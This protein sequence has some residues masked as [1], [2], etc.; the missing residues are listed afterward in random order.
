MNNHKFILVLFLSFFLSM[1]A[2]AD[3]KL[4]SILNDNMVLQ[5]NSRVKLWGWADKGEKITIKLSWTKEII[6]TIANNEGKWIVAFRTIAAGGPYRIEIEG[7]NKIILNNILLGE[8][9]ICSG[10]SNMEFTI[11]MLGGW[12]YYKKEFEDLMQYDYSNVRLCQIEKDASPQLKDDCKSHWMKADSS[13][14]GNFSATAWFF[15]RELSKRLKVPI[16]LV[17]SNWGGTQA[18]A[19]TETSFLAKDKDLSY[20]LTKAKANEAYPAIQSSLYNAMINPLINYVIKGAIWYQGESNIDEAELYNKLFPA[21]IKSWRQAWN[22]GDFPFYYVQIA[23]YNYSGGINSSA[24]LREAQMKALNVVNTG[25]VVTLDIGDVNNI[26]PKDKSAVGKRLSLWALN[27]TYLQKDIKVFSGPVYKKMK[28]ERT[29]IRLYFDHANSGLMSK[30]NNISGF[31]IAGED[32]KFITAD[33]VIDGSTLLVSAKN[34]YKP[35]AVRYA[36]TDTSTATLFNM[37]GLPASSFRTDKLF[38]LTRKSFISFEKDTITGDN[39]AVMTGNDINSLIRYSID[40]SE[41]S[42]N[43]PLY[44]EKILL[45]KTMT[46]K[47]K[48]FKGN[49]SSICSVEANFHKHNAW[50]NNIE[51]LTD[52]SSQYKGSYN[53]LTDGIRGSANFL[54]GLWQGFLGDDVIVTIDME[55]SKPIDKIKLSFLQNINSWI[56]APLYIDIYTSDN[57]I[58]FKLFTS[59]KNNTELTKE[60]SFIKEFDVEMK[61]IKAKYIKVIAK[62]IGLCPIWHVGANNKAWIFIDEIEVY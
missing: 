9:W 27:K 35:M 53:V 32:M 6:T 31:T 48:V 7:N 37:E 13:T 18:E 5:Q 47:A 21:M 34:I 46:L 33:A 45:Q 2:Y 55:T 51:Y 60:G 19:W 49:L 3:I 25:M 41:P 28:V 54:D 14:L 59:V 57:N 42:F 50:G 24:Y 30:N 56:F 22:I 8:V 15:G 11:N 12:G 29:H 26:H 20:Y 4:P 40:G 62:N 23:P 39:Y 58:D 16:A 52:F 61:L 10:Q 36:F 1:H 38:F 17:S 44:K 43:S